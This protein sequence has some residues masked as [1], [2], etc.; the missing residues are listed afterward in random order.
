M[1]MRANCK[2]NLGL[3]ILRRREDGYHDLETVMVPVHG[4]YDELTIERIA[5]DGVL[6]ESAGLKVD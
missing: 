4:L 6:F 3:D 2:I 5:G 1:K